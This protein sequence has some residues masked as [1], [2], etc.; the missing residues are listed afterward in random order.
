M[1]KILFI[2]HDDSLSGAP[3]LLMNLIDLINEEK[4]YSIKIVIKN[5]A[6][7]LSE[8][9]SKRVET[10]IWKQNNKLSFLERILKKVFRS[11]KKFYKNQN[12][13]QH[14]IDESDVLISNTITNG[15]FFKSFDFTKVN[16]VMSYVHELEYVTSIFSNSEDFKYLFSA[17]MNFMVPSKAVALHL[18]NNLNIPA[19]KISYLN[20]YIPSKVKEVKPKNNLDSDFFIGMVGTLEWR[21]GIDL[22]PIIVAYFF[23]THP[24]SNVKFIWKGASKKGFEYEKVLFELKKI[25]KIDKVIFESPSMEME[26]F[27]NTIDVLLM[28]SKE[29]PYPL[30]VLEAASYRRPTVCFA[31]AGGAPEFVQEDAGA[32]VPYLDIESL[33]DRLHEFSIDNDKCIKKGLVAYNRFT[34]LHFSKSLIKQQFEQNITV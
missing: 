4:K 17:N 6:G 1:K 20:Y 34:E 14:W 13:I 32:I 9:F 16:K 19:S 30:V 23:K 2:S 15:D 27:Y 11:K 12:K 7:Y 22:L 3:M 21:K 25:D 5:K 24:L 10:L 26:T 33:V 29:D 8:E 31:N 28:C 18:I